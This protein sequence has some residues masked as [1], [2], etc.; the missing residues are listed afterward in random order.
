MT[1]T[2]SS[3]LRFFAAFLRFIQEKWVDSREIVPERAVIK[4]SNRL[5]KVEP[6]IRVVRLRQA[7][8]KV[9]RLPSGETIEWSHRWVVER[10]WRKQWY[11]SLQCHK[12]IV[13]E[14]YIK[15]PLD[16]PLIVNDRVFV[17]DR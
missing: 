11:P 5:R 17:V 7:E 1:D 9:R 12:P 2:Q 8:H 14:S 6:K 10:H 16:K 4:R 15:G 3:L 13:I